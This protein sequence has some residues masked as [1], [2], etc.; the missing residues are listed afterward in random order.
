MVFIEK[1]LSIL[2]ST[3]SFFFMSGG[4]L[5]GLGKLREKMVTKEEL[6]EN[7]KEFEVK[8]KEKRDECNLGD[9]LEELKVIVTKNH[10]EQSK[11]IESMDDKR[12]SAKDQNSEVMIKINTSIGL[13]TGQ[14]QA[15]TKIRN[16]KE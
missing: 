11:K 3:L 6:E 2:I 5:F 12:E 9:K 16:G 15:L 1:Y 7:N 10:T 14:V 4:L 13:L 8:C